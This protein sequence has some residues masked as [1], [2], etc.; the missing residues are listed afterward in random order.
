MSFVEVVGMFAVTGG[1][2][3]RCRQV[4][5]TSFAE[6]DGSAEINGIVSTPVGAIGSG[7]PTQR[8]RRTCHR[9]G[10]DDEST[11]ARTTSHERQ[12]PGVTH[13]RYGT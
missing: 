13:H 8:T 11:Q 1:P 9:H 7:E 4:R 12:G 10:V 3:A 6:A 2:P 5:V